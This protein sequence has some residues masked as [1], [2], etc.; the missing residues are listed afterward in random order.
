[1]RILL[2]LFLLAGCQSYDRS[3]HLVLVNGTDDPIYYWVSCDSSFS[4]MNFNSIYMLKAHDTVMPYLL[5]GDEGKGP[6]KNTWINAINRA[7]DSA[8]HVFYYYIDF[9]H[10]PARADSPF[11]LMIR[12]CDY[13]AD[14]LESMGWRLT[15]K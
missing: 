8:L 2:L 10:R 9:K 14:S 3:A 6:N 4:D 12:R 13:T 7:D 5:Y 11:R 1:M 15:Y